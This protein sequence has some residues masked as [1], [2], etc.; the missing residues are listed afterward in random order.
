MWKK[1]NRNQGRWLTKHNE[2]SFAFCVSN[3]RS[4][5]R[6]TTFRSFFFLFKLPENLLSALPTLTQSCKGNDSDDCCEEFHCRF[7]FVV[8]K[9]KNS[10]WSRFLC[11]CRSN[12]LFLSKR[13]RGNLQRYSLKCLLYIQQQDQISV[14]LKLPGWKMLRNVAQKKVRRDDSSSKSFR[15]I[16]RLLKF[17]FFQSN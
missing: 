8:F 15:A 9:T 11:S 3:V 1:K 14:K 6:E 12:W 4:C 13:T 2:T 5:N 16:L 17:H 7:F 10:S